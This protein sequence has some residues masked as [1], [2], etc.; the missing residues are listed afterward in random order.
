MGAPTRVP[1]G[2]KID[3]PHLVVRGER[4]GFYLY[5]SQYENLFVRC[6]Y[7]ARGRKIGTIFRDFNGKDKPYVFMS[8]YNE[9]LHEVWIRDILS[10]LERMNAQDANTQGVLKEWKE[11]ARQHE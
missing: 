11:I 1:G 8:I 5:K 2:V 6:V 10:V 3:P 4:I 7:L 9:N